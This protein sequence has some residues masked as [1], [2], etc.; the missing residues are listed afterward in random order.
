MRRLGFARVLPVLAAVMA[1]ALALAAPV[2]ARALAADEP[3]AISCPYALLV[4]T[5]T[6]TVLLDKDADA[7][8]YPASVT[9]V[10]TALVTLETLD[11]DDEVTVEEGDFDNVPWYSSVA[12]LK[13]G[14]T[15]TV[16]D[17][18][19]CLLLPSGNEAA[20]VLA[21]AVGGGDWHACI[22]LMNQRAAE[23]GCEGTHFVNPCGLHDDNHYSTARDLVRIYEAALEHPE[24]REIAGSAYWELPETSEN[25]ARTL[26]ST[27]LLCLPDSSVY[28]DGVTFTGKTGST[29]EGGRSLIVSAEKDGRSLVAVV[30]GVAYDSM[31]GDAPTSFSDMRSVL[32]WG[33]SAWRTGEVLA[34]GDVVGSREVTLSDDGDAVRALAT[35]GVVATVPAEVTADDLEFTPTWEGALQAPVESGQRLGEVRVSYAGRELGTVG[36]VADASLGLSIPAFVIWWVTSDPLHIAIVGVVGVAAVALVV[37]ALAASSRR[38]QRELQRAAAARRPAVMPVVSSSARTRRAATPRAGGGSS[39]RGRSGGSHMRR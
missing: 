34:A 19:A 17:L 15:L 13:A 25:P 12:G 36:A 10:M 24:F 39:R 23:L 22:D 37:R 2:R 28:M 7:R 8:L 6:D 1:V 38:H 27:N 32:E 35:D 26:T 20:Y 11:L 33:F 16:R 14:E 9:K 29:T 18:L 5:A 31:T 3:P 4:D 21:R 30:S